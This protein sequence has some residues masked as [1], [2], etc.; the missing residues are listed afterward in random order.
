MNIGDLIE[1]ISIFSLNK[2][3]KAALNS[4]KRIEIQLRPGFKS[5]RIWFR[6]NQ[7]F[8]R[9]ENIGAD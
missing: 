3:D 1:L 9:G 4:M 7:T 6:L 5:S 2:L 8:I